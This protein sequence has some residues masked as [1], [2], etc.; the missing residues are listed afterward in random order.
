MRATTD[1][2]QVEWFVYVLVS[3]SGRTY[4][5]VTTD[6]ERR[7]DQHN[8][9]K[10]GGAKATRAHR[11]WRLGKV[12][13]GFTRSEACKAEYQIKKLSGLSRL[14]WKRPK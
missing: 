10:P 5:G 7:L 14:D 6:P 11:P 1:A 2:K 12:W 9:N 13:S 8:G 3:E 4:C